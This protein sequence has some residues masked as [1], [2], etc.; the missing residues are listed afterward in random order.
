MKAEVG[1]YHAPKDEQDKARAGM[2]VEGQSRRHDAITDARCQ[3][4]TC[5]SIERS[6]RRFCP[7]L[8]NPL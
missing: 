1:R 7:N 2:P 6:P 3:E 4:A 8:I 5:R